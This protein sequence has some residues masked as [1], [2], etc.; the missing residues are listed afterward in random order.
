MDHSEYF[1]SLEKI[2]SKWRQL[3][4]EGFTQKLKDELW[5]LC[6][7]GQQLFFKMVQ[8]DKALGYSIPKSVR[9]YQRVVMLLEQE[10]RYNDAIR[11][12]EQANKPGINTDWYSKKICKYQKLL[13]H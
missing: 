2:E 10:K 9:C 7:Q 6:I 12:C 13:K 8:K 1:G 11:L 4:S 3:K 5:L